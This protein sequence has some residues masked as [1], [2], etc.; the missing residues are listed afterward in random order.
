MH[1]FSC[2]VLLI[3][4][5]HNVSLAQPNLVGYY[6]FCNC[7][8]NDNSG[9][10]NHGT[11]VGNPS[12][13]PGQRGEGFLFN[14]N[15]GA[16]GCGQA[17]GEYVQLPPLG[18]IWQEG[19]TVCAWVRFDVVSYYERII[20]FGNGSGDS[21]GMPIWFGREGASNNLTLESWITSS[22]AVNRTLGR[23]VAPNVITNGNIEYYCA[24]IS[25]DTMRIYVN[26]V[27]KAQKKG[28][29]ILNV[30]RS[31][32][33]IGRS[34][35]CSA[36]PDFKGFM[37]EIRIYN[38]A[39]TEAEIN[40]L[41]LQTPTFSA[42][43][44]PVFAGVPVQLEAKG[45]IAYLWS[46]AA[47][48]DDPNIP[49]PIATPYETTTYT[50][51]ITLP[52]GCV[53]TDSLRIEVILANCSSTC[54]GT[55]GDNIF[56]NGDF[57]SGVPNIV[58]TDP[59]LA[60]GYVY[61]V[62]PPPNDGFYCIANNTTTWGSFAANAWI[63]IEDNGP[64][65]NGY[66]MVVNASYQPGLFYQKTVDVCEN[67]LYEFSID[68]ISLIESHL[69]NLIRPN[70]AFLIDGI[71]V[72]QTGD[73]P[74]DELWHTVRFSFTTGPGQT[75]INL[76]L[77]NNA[78][79]GNGN[80][81][82]IDNI[83]FRACGP[84]LLAPE[85]VEF[86]KGVPTTIASVLANSPYNN[87][88][89]LWQIYANGT[90]EDLPDSNNDSLEIFDPIDG[91]LFR[92]VV[93]SS[94]PNLAMLNCRVISDTVQLKLLPDLLVNATA[95]DVSCAGGS[96]ATAAAAAITGT[97]PYEYAW[98][99]GLSGSNLINLSAGNY[100][101][102]ITDVLGCTGVATVSITEPPLLT[103]SATATNISCF[104]IQDATATV[105]VSGGTIPYQYAWSTGQTSANLANL[106]PGNYQVTITDG[107][108]CTEVSTL[109]VSE[110]TL[111]T[112]SATATDVSC[113]GIQDATAAVSV[114][115]GTIPYQYAWSNGQTSANLGNLGPG[116]Y[117]VTIT[118]ENACTEVA[119]VSISE[120]ALLNSSATA[121]NVTCYGIQDATAAV[122]VSG[123]TI[124]YQYVWNTG[125]TSANLANLGPGNYQ[126]TITDGNACTEVA[127]VSISEPPLLASSATATD[128]T[129]YGIQDAT[130]SVSVSGGT[131]PYQYVWINGQTSANLANLGPGT[132]QVTIM[133][134]NA[135]T[136][137][138]TVSISEPTLLN[139][140][141]TATN[142]TCSGAQD[143]TAS[144]SVAGGTIPYQY[145]WSNG[146]TSANLSNL[147][148]GTYH[149]TITDSNAC[150]E[151][152]T[153]N[154]SEP[155]LLTSSATATNVSCFGAQDAVASVS[156][157]GGTIPYQFIWSTGQTSDNLADLGPGNYQFTI[158]DG[159]ACTEVS[160]VNISEPALLSS[161]STATDVSCSGI[162]DA[163]AAVLVAGGTLPYQ[164]VWS[165]GQTSANL[166]NLAPGTYQVTITDD[167]SCTATSATQVNAP[168]PLIVQTHKTNITCYGDEDGTL[169][170][171]VSGGVAPYSFHWN[172]GQMTPVISG[173]SAGNY[174]L[175]VTDAN[176]C[177]IAANAY[178]D[179][180]IL[181]T[182]HLDTDLRI[183][184]GDLIDLKA[185]VNLPPS[186]V[187]DYTW[188]GSE[189]SLHCADCFLYSFQPTG[190]GCQQVLVR[191]KK[192]CVAI[193]TVCYQILR[194]R[195]VYAPNVFSPNGDG[196]NDFFTIFSDDG[197]KQI[198]SLSIYNRWGGHI[199]Q[200]Y[201]IQTNEEPAGWDGT[202]K[203]QTL[204]N[205][206]FVWVARLE[207]IDGEIISM[208]GDVT[209]VR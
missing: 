115:G 193:D 208:K 102:T 167:N 27:L 20:D 136:E 179:E 101:V 10:G 61:S 169:S 9:F 175:S 52:D 148:P 205:D 127:T 3:S 11:L 184:L 156:V 15:P 135:C 129:C 96:N 70:I 99:S 194:Q 36:D 71:A 149:V 48:L 121:T 104:G 141:A 146:Q 90:W 144:V 26:G 172:S 113:F 29:P 209:L 201:N 33:F 43:Q 76:A 40:S 170:A 107:N 126:V 131:I 64:E 103:A 45:G 118:D 80:D 98:D 78:P 204:N 62:N 119:T 54:T 186:E 162:Q 8:A 112:S 207:F 181:L 41:Y 154:I 145:V 22:G 189:D 187:M 75:S 65:T 12:C 159:N 182:V 200:A 180:P 85:I 108:A 18:A 147:A 117:Q 63:N 56:P 5:N 114:A 110:P 25:G 123:G 67:T 30:P 16:N 206:V 32:N 168:P 51:Q 164:Y 155:T 111:L 130:A 171:V 120:P 58:A 157:S 188:S 84:T 37:D 19:F 57:G 38:R 34:N 21:G 161:S 203:G 82:A 86:C 185:A 49:N 178:L 50:C 124:P 95:Q 153:V 59:G 24:T 79:G 163:N 53:Y 6:S 73:I 66:M 140:S 88:V 39:L 69:P 81:L 122:A 165:T 150:T 174:T 176:G 202:F 199:Y 31:K 100:W 195:R 151:V 4:I 109:N 177:T 14:Q 192:G 89:Y 42:Y 138:S 166:S 143:A 23:L 91:S 28:H 173:L 92:L 44:S 46:P 134:G 133:D 190:P 105:S 72:C 74:P 128:V 83:S 60:P 125:Q 87:P 191:S 137:V 116:N 55:L 197:V 132:Y 139:S 158:T 77:R 183:H 47:G 68:V 152:S 97:A 17:G 35:W 13:V 160:T 198:L 196:A 93:A 1:R 142:V 94:L 7:N 106:G 2:F